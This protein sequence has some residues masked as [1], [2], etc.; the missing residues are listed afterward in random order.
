VSVPPRIAR[1]IEA[2]RMEPFDATDAD[3]AALWTKAIASARDSRHPA[4]SIDNR[5]SLGYQALL[6]GAG[7]VL[8]TAG[9]RPRGRGPGHHHDL[10]YAVSGLSIPGAEDVDVRTER[11]RRQRSRAVY[12]AGL[13]TES[14]VDEVYRLQDEFLPAMH[15]WLTSRRPGIAARLPPWPR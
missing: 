8:M 2:R 6:Q 4:N 5:H 7:A 15:R 1:L 14:E 11:A 12:E 10:F 3:V 13:S 9:Y